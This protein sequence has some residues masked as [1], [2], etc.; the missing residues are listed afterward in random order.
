[1]RI[2]P[3]LE[4]K[5]PACV[6][7][8]E[9]SGCLAGPEF[10]GLWEQDGALTI[11]W[12]GTEAMLRQAV[13]EAL[14]QLK[15]TI[16]HTAIQ[17]QQV[18]HQDWNAQWAASVKPLRLGRRIG[19]RPSWATM[20]MPVDGIELV[21]DPKQA[22][23]TGHHATT[24]LLVEWLEDLGALTDCRVLDVGTGSGILSMVALRLGALSAVG[25]DLDAVAIDCAKGYAVVNGFANELILRTCRI[26]ELADESFEIIV[27]N[28][29]RKSLLAIA[30]EFSRMR[31]SATQ[32]FLSG[33][34][35][36]DES[37]IVDRFTSQGW[38]PQAIRKREGWIALQFGVS[39][40]G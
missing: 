12:Q 9:L 3:T 19:I 39:S 4:M 13:H 28:I 11:Y 14:A 27:A 26:D 40:V 2:S 20:E 21:I 15:N 10:L 36:D 25:I 37:E 1:M 5:I 34:L 24:H 33:L 32:L 7:G 22:F 35:E 17:V 18:I 30:S 31:S 23:G 29:D 38:T 8:A 16:P 6:D